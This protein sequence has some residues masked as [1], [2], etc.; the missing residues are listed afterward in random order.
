MQ[1]L[2]LVI[3]G[4]VGIARHV[5]DRSHG[6]GIVSRELGIDPVARGEQPGGAGEIRDVGIRLAGE[7]R[8]PGEPVDL[9]ALDLG[10]PVGALHQAHHHALAAADGEVDEI[11]DHE[12]R[13]LLVGLNDEAESCPAGQ[14]GVEGKRLQQVERELEPFGLFGIDVQTD[15]VRTGKQAQCL[16]VGQQLV[17]RTIRLRPDVA[18]MQGGQLDRDPVAIDD[19]APCRVRADRVDR[20]LV[21]LVVALRIAAGQRR[22]AQHVEGIAIATPLRPAAPRQRFVDIAP[23]HELLAQQAHRQIHALA[24]QRFAATDQHPGERT[25]Q[26]RLAAGRNQPPGHEQP[27]GRRVHEQRRAMA[28][29]GT[30]VAMGEFVSNQAIG[31]GVVGHAQQGLGQAHQRDPFL[32]RKRE[33]LHQRID[34]RRTA[35]RATQARNQPRGERLHPRL[36]SGIELRRGDQGRHAA[37]LGHAVRVDDRPTQAGPGQG[38]QGGRCRRESDRVHDGLHSCA[39]QSSGAAEYRPSSSA[40]CGRERR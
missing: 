27:P 7:Y 24:D 10:I 5:H 18:W 40:A 31:R 21:R 17:L 14:I 15:I 23:G 26:A 1:A 36:G 37:W 32:A 8:I 28:Q 12:G 30:P 13:A 34:A 16:D 9:G 11:V 22:L 33:L 3:A 6:M 19:P 25:R 2:K 20:A 4:R 39:N 29:V 35:A 38:R